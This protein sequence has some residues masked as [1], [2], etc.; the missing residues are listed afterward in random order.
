MHKKSHNSQN[1]DKNVTIH[2]ISIRYR[3]QWQTE[4]KKDDPNSW[5]RTNLIVTIQ[6]AQPMTPRSP[7]YGLEI[8]RND[9]HSNLAVEIQKW[10][11]LEFVCT[12]ARSQ[13]TVRRVKKPE[14]LK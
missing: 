9:M 6:F 14:Y 1:L 7:D 12:Q 11:S 3:I 5:D 4:G 13:K 8:Q 2:L 10:T